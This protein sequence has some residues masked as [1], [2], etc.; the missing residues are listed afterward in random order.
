LR[1]L[2]IDLS[3]LNQFEHFDAALACLAF[4]EKGM[5]PAHSRGHVPLCQSSFFTGGNQLAEKLI[6]KS[7]MMRGPSF[8]GHA[9]LGL[10]LLLHLPSL[11]NS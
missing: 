3:E 5:S 11:V 2:V 7:L 6:V 10:P 1:R 9:G 8:T 4:R